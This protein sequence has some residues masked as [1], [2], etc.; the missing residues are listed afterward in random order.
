DVG[1]AAPFV[2][3]ATRLA[4]CGGFDVDDPT[5]LA[6]AAAAAGLSLDA[7]L[8]AAGDRG[9][10]RALRVKGERLA[11]QGLEQLPALQVGKT[12]FCGEHRLAEAAAYV[13]R[14]PA[15]LR[16]VAAPGASGP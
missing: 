11:A 9:L 8:A 2:L 13:S 10:D 12:V 16:H 3:A 14:G 15:P 4:F 1:R 7:C 6:E 5:I